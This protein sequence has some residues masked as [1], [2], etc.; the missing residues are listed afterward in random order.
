[1]TFQILTNSYFNFLVYL[2]FNAHLHYL[3]VPHFSLYLLA[4]NPE[5]GEKCHAVIFHFIL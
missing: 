2:I 4:N 1:M 3:C 5:Q